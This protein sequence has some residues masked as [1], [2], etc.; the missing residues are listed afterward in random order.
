MNKLIML[1]LNDGALSLIYKHNYFHKLALFPFCALIGTA[2]A[3]L[4]LEIISKDS[5]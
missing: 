2:F 4:L 3:L 1:G 5:K